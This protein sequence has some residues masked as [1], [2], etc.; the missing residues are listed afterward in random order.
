MDLKDFHVQF[1]PNNHKSLMNCLIRR[2]DSIRDTIV[3]RE[4]RYVI[5]SLRDELCRGKLFLF[6][7]TL[8]DESMKA[9]YE[10]LSEGQRKIMKINFLDKNF[11]KVEKMKIDKKEA[12]EDEKIKIKKVENMMA[13][14]VKNG[15]MSGW[16][17]T[18]LM[19]SIYNNSTN[20]FCNFWH[21]NRFG[22]VP[23]NYITQGDDTHFKCRFATQAMFHIGLVNSIGKIA[24]P[25][26]QFFS[27]G[28]T[29]FLK[30]TY[31]L[32]QTKMYY[33]PVRMI[34]SILYE[35]E[36]RKSKANNKNNMKD[37]IDVW[38]L[39]MIRIPNQ[40]RREFIRDSGYAQECVRIKFKW[41]TKQQGEKNKIDIDKLFST[42]SSVNG[43]LLG[44]LTQLKNLCIQS[45]EFSNI[46]FKLHKGY[47]DAEMFDYEL[48]TE[49]ECKEKNWIGIQSFVTN[50]LRTASRGKKG[51]VSNKMR[52]QMIRMVFDCV[53][54]SLRE[55]R[56]LKVLGRLNVVKFHM[57][58]SNIFMQEIDLVFPKIMNFFMNNMKLYLNGFDLA[59]PWGQLM[60]LNNR[61]S[62]EL[63]L[64]LRRSNRS[65][66]NYDIFNCLSGL[67]NSCKF[68]TKVFQDL[69]QRMSS[70]TLFKFALSEDIGASI[71]RYI[72]HDEYLGMFSLIINESIPLLFK[73][74]INFEEII[75]RHKILKDN[76]IT[77]E[78]LKLMRERQQEEEERIG[79]KNDAKRVFD[80]WKNEGPFTRDVYEEMFID[81]LIKVIEIYIYLN[82]ARLWREIRDHAIGLVNSEPF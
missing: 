45:D 46:G 30:K 5:E 41:H 54:E 72:Q 24:H 34:S 1:G 37:V 3:R 2:L 38:N 12:L 26:K 53:N 10:K 49:P 21:L 70:V 36:N 7:S 43:Y 62:K 35:K 18:S 22:L 32:F 47:I 64:G 82:S 23:T 75:E 68:T 69:L 76:K 81:I 25:K 9:A 78:E 29:E 44:P 51:L 28:M 31:D 63:E 11:T 17:L 74:I 33:S 80:V 58:I 79:K 20:V 14:D 57:D 40:R 52:T 56:E 61:L 60:I 65:M 59:T 16:K 48:T 4:L 39:F 15:L 50:V 77:E 71:T 19:G 8:E 42:P 13:F 67:K 73:D 55:Y 6:I 27:T 66:K